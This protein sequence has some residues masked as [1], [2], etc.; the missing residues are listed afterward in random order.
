[1]TAEPTPDWNDIRSLAAGA[2]EALLRRL[3]DRLRRA[4]T[5]AR[6]TQFQAAQV[7]DVTPQTIRNWETGR[8]EPP[9]WAI[10]KLAEAYKTSEN[11]LLRDLNTPFEL[12][13]PGLRFPYDRVFV[14]AR[15]ALTSPKRLRAY[16]TGCRLQDEC[17]RQRHQALRKRHLQPYDENPSESG[18]H[19]R[20]TGWLVHGKRPFHR[21]GTAAIRSVN[22][23][24]TNSRLPERP[25]HRWLRPN[26]G[27]PA[28]RR[29]GANTRIHDF[30]SPARYVWPRIPF[31]EIRLQHPFALA[32]GRVIPQRATR[33]G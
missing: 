13:P 23:M 21:R 11:E 1:M 18:R 7:V 15:K 30:H 19:L 31:L 20:Q 29:Q 8:N 2:K 3:G 17:Q 12:P 32:A 22:H 6:L 26:P 9:A 4:R 27:R 33:M 10:G 16:P 14:D 25:G 24:D 28:R 5:Q